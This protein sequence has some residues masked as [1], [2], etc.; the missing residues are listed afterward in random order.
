V[1]ASAALIDVP[2]EAA[3]AD[4]PPSICYN[5]RAM[6][7]LLYTYPRPPQEWTYPHCPLSPAWALDWQKL[8]ESLPWLQTLAG[9]PQDAVFHAEG[10]V[11]VHTRMVVAALTGL[12]AWRA[13]SAEERALLFA[14]ALL[15]DIGKPACTATDETG[16]IHSRGHARLGERMVRQMFWE[17]DV[18]FA[19]REYIARLVR[20]HALPV[21]FLDKPSPER[22]LFAASLG[23]NLQHLA[24]LAEADMR[25]RVC[26]D[27]QR[28]LDTIE[29][30]RGYGEELA[31]LNQPRQFASAHS[32]FVYFHSERADADPAYA[33]YDDTRCE[34][35]LMAGLPGVGKDTW[36]RQHLEGWPVISLDEIRRELKIA[37]GEN[38]GGV[39]QLARQRARELLRQHTSFVWNATNIMRMR[40]QELVDMVTAYGGR[41]RIVY[42]DAPLSAI[43]QRN[44]QRKEKERVPDHI[45]RSF[46]RRMEVP[47]Q[48]EAHSVEWICA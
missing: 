33:A 48:T 3:Q 23:V 35:V 37:P 39:I 7:R 12:T 28:L 1:P 8:E 38:Q 4:F 27:Q 42:L 6:D 25:G 41:V 30:F 46:A 47:D 34:V 14:S 19:F 45:I 10:D 40:R 26:E 2:G 15:H 9:V 18:P 11:L 21:Q 32:R 13:L 5:S 24:L 29:L 31:C 44:Q 22:A 20:L 36:V 16:H 17:D 43:L